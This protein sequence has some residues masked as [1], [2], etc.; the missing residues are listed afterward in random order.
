MKHNTMEASITELAPIAKQALK[1]MRERADKEW[2]EKVDEFYEENKT[3][4]WYWIGKL[5]YPTRESVE[6]YFGKVDKP[7]QMVIGTH[8]HE[9]FLRTQQISSY[10]DLVKLQKNKPNTMVTM[11]VESYNVLKTWEE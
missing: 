6:I 10:E 7:S 4:R 3:A 5:I 11:T 8:F 9:L 2:T 1:G